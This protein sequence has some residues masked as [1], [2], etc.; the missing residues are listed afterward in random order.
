MRL[1]LDEDS[2]KRKAWSAE[3]SALVYTK[4][5]YMIIQ[6]NYKHKEAKD[7]TKI[8]QCSHQLEGS[9]TV[10]QKTKGADRSSDD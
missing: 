2:A 1:Y 3:S 9:N 10:M 8:I 6:L 4:L 5:L 7:K